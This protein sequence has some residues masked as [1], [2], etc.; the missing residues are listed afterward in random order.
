MEYN[1]PP[2]FIW[3]VRVIS[4]VSLV[5]ALYATANIFQSMWF[6]FWSSRTID[7]RTKREFYVRKKYDVKWSLSLVIVAMLGYINS[8]LVGLSALNNW[9]LLVTLLFLIL[10]WGNHRVLNIE[11]RRLERKKEFEI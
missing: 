6:R 5:I 3:P 10:F 2:I 4:F 9:Y 1:Y 8:L 11:K 7:D